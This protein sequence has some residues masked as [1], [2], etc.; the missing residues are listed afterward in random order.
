MFV[1]L[2][3]FWLLLN[4]KVTLEIAL[5]GL[6]VSAAVYAFMVAFM[7]YSPRKEWQLVKRTGRIFRYGAYLIKEVF[8]SSVAVIRLIWSPKLE[9]EPRL[10]TFH[11]KLKTDAGK[12]VLAN[13]ITLTPGTM[14]VDIHEDR[15]L[16]HCLDASFDVDHENF[17]MESRV[18]EVEGGKD[19]E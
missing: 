3:C 5:V 8:L 2:F 10:T 4:G 6:V 12:T 18:A 9:T 14:T 17:E 13:S 11:T 7:G 16:I 19:H 1:V 15:F